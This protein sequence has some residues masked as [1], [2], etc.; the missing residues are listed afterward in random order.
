MAQAMGTRN[1]LAWFDPFVGCHPRVAPYPD[2]RQPDGDRTGWEYE[3]NG[4]N[5]RAGM[6]PPP[7]PDKMRRGV[8]RQGYGEKMEEEVLPPWAVQEARRAAEI[9]AL[10]G[11]WR[12]PGAE[13]RAVRARQEADLR[14]WREAEGEGYEYVDGAGAYDVDG[15]SEEEDDGS[16]EDDDDD[17]DAPRAVQRQ[18]RF[19]S[20][21]DGEPGWTNAEGDRLRDY[22][23]DEDADEDED[24]DIPLGELLRRRKAFRGAEV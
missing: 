23:V 14:R 5:T 9:A 17:G 16:D 2:P 13:V 21:V 6:W 24:D 8:K 22:G 15:Q 11:R 3:E 10:E 20:G 4:F 19:E 1:P 12:D 18:T 7:D